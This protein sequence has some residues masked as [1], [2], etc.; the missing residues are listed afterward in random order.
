MKYIIITGCLGFI[1][2]S[3]TNFFLRK[4]KDYKV[5]GI[6]KITYAANKKKLLEFKKNQKFKFFKEDIYNYNK[7]KKIF[8]SHDIYHVINFAAETHVDTSITTPDV[9]IKSNIHGTYN[10]LKLSTEKWINNK[11]KKYKNSCYLQ[12][13]TD[14]VYGSI[15]K[16]K[17]TEKS[18]F[19]PNSPYSSSKA[20]ADL[21]VRSFN[22]TYKL[23]TIITN[24][25]NNFGPEQNKEK[26]IPTIVNSLIKKIDIP[27]YG[28]GK[29]IRNWI[30]VNENCEALY[31][32]LFNGKYGE[33]YNIGSDIEY[34]NYSLAKKICY[35]YKKITKSDFDF[36]KLIKFVKDRPGHD[37][38]YSLNVNKIR[39]DCN[40]KPSNNFNNHIKKTIIGIINNK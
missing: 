22:K 14:E 35:L 19:K 24:S 25:A 2:S 26:L 23:N 40:W 28:D 18:P 37:L 3:F 17:F 5:I 1:G 4:N 6:D 10:L 15:K 8:N 36:T 21:L 30:F 13:S 16:G 33:N 32:I 20:A 12:I 38:R 29:N 7:I 11:N 39:N 9:F 27:I 34:T 31:K